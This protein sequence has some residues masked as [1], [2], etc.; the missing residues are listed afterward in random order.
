MDLTMTGIAIGYAMDVE[1]LLADPGVRKFVDWAA[2][3]DTDFTATMT[4]KQR[5][6]PRRMS[7]RF[8]EVTFSAI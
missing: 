1:G 2:N 5:Q 8:R 3:K 4:K 6:S 7:A